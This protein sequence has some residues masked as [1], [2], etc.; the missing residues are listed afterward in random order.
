MVARETAARTELT[1]RSMGVTDWLLSLLSSSW[2]GRPNAPT[3]AIDDLRYPRS[4]AG[5]WRSS[6]A[7]RSWRSGVYYNPVGA[8]NMLAGRF[9]HLIPMLALAGSMAPKRQV[10]PSLGT[11]PTSSGLFAG[12]VIGTIVIVGALSYFAALA[13]GP[14]TEHLALLAGQTLP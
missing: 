9:G 2:T 12:F 7:T 3:T 5:R 8:F 1:T 4:P 13:L 6:S 14:I 10:A 11:L